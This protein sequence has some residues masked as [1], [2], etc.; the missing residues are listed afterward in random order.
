MTITRRDA[1]V[2]AVALGLI[3]N[4]PP[5]ART[6]SNPDASPA[7][8]RLYAYLWSV[9]GWH[10][11]SGQQESMWSR[12]GPTLEL[13]YIEKLSGKRP[14]VLGLD[15]IEPSDQLATNDRAARWYESGGIPTLCWHW[16]VPTIGTGYENSKK[17]FDV[18]A[19]LAPGTP[20]NAAM[21]RDLGHVADLLTALRDR[22]VPVLWRPFHEFSGDWFWWGKHGPD[23]FKA[24]WTL[25]YDMFTRR[26]GLS[27]LIWVLGWA[28]QNVDA[29]YDPGRGYYDIAGADIYV[30]DHGNLA[31][32]F[33][34]VKAIVGE[35]VPICLH[36]NGAIPD[37]ATLGP[38]ADWLYF[39]TWHTRW[40]MDG[41]LNTPDQIGR[42]YASERYLT[43]DELPRLATSSARDKR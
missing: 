4:S 3:G 43:K 22:G 1:L 17:D 40:I 2:G 6:L 32:M 29:R 19:A 28:G 21:M 24:L 42:F 14:A 18:A 34:R 8:R 5:P 39:L 10:T 7:A 37:P 30:D 31:P 9:Y 23:A 15:Y 26:R 35:N 41:K 11:L 38:G 27:N 12:E 16:G 13:D 36:E 25:M 20:E 33:A